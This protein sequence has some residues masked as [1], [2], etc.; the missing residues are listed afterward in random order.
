MDKTARL[1]RISGQ[2]RILR[3]LRLILSRINGPIRWI[4]SFGVVPNNSCSILS[5]SRCKIAAYIDKV[6]SYLSY[7]KVF[8]MLHRDLKKNNLF[9]SKIFPFFMKY[10]SNGVGLQHWNSNK[11]LFETKCKKT[12][13]NNAMRMN[14]ALTD[15]TTTLMF[16]VQNDKCLV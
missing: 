11:L 1:V 10:N 8:K 6:C 12:R 5:S 9:R 3:K 13:L 16:C 4:S 2:T 7:K 15:L 14:D